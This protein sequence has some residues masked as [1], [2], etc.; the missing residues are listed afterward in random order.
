MHLLFRNRYE[1]FE[2][3]NSPTIL[4]LELHRLLF[5]DLLKVGGIRSLLVCHLS[6]ERQISKSSW[7]PWLHN[8]VGSHID[9]VC[10]NAGPG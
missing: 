1:G 3:I 4:G 9:R 7:N 5:Q 6:N 8:Q 10:H 2:L